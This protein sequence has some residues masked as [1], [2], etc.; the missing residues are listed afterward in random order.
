MELKTHFLDWLAGVPVVMMNEKTAGKV[1]VPTKGRVL[2]RTISKN[3][4][5]V[6]A[7]TNLVEGIIGEKEIGVSEEVIKRLKLKKDQKVEV[8]L[9]QSPASIRLIKKK[10]DGKTL[11]DKEIDEIIRDVVNN[12][13]TDPEVALFVSAMYEHGMNLSETISLIRAILLTGNKLTFKHKYVVDKHSIGGIAGRTTPIVVSICAAAGLTFPKTSS[14]AITSAAGTADIIEGVA[15]VD[16][17]PDQIKS[18]VK[19]ANACIV[20]GG[21]LGLVPADSKI[22]RVEKA[23]KIDPEAQLLASIISKKLAVGSKYIVIDIPYGNSAKVD[24]KKALRLKNKFENLGK[25]FKRNI[26]CLL[27][28]NKGPLGNGVGPA[29]ELIDVLRVLSGDDP[30]HNLE[31]RSLELAGALLEMTNK[32]KK[33]QGELL[34]KK[35]LYSGKALQKFEQII[36]LQKGNLARVKIGKFRK[37]IY[38]KKSGRILE[39]DNKKINSLGRVTGSPYYKGSGI[40][41]HA[42][43]GQRV[44]KGD[45]LITIYSESSQGLRQ[46]VSFYNKNNPYKIQ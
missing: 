14:R 5:E 30:C 6:M 42:H 28:E 40:Y 7:V 21:S 39:I 37:K 1:G 34:A 3:S 46:A 32:A 20:W 19:K 9:A 27:I 29:L 12:S 17:N 18:I 13:L 8:I 26:R 45:V 10:L 22:I 16:L 24:K 35:I 36:K 43:E 41:I 2:L 23:L 11:N 44:K 33:G 38:S 25:Y 4:R 15:E 31:K